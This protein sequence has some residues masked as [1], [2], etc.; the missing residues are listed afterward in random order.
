M[1]GLPSEAQ[2]PDRRTKYSPD[3][4]AMPPSIIEAQHSGSMH[5]LA[6]GDHR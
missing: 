2:D 4:F 5:Q 1:P 6:N 3:R